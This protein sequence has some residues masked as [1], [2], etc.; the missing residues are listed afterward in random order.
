MLGFLIVLSSSSEYTSLINVKKTKFIEKSFEFKVN[1][2]SSSNWKIRN[3]TTFESN[4]KAI[5]KPGATTK[6]GAFYRNDT[7]SDFFGNNK[8]KYVQV[9]C[10][11]SV[12]NG[13]KD[14][15][16]YV[17][18]ISGHSIPYKFGANSN[19]GKTTKIYGL[20]WY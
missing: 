13:N 3:V 17:D 16:C 15:Y 9:S 7:K 19:I 8:Y 6:T 18:I 2:F 1:D 4:T 10:K 12:D 5:V 14:A 11:G 20:I